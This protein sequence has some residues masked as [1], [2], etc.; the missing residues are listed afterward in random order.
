MSLGSWPHAGIACLWESC[1]PLRARLAGAEV[2]T[3]RF[4]AP[5][6]L[7]IPA[8]LSRRYR[9]GGASPPQTRGGHRGLAVQSG[10]PAAQGTQGSDNRQ[11]RR[12]LV[13]V[14]RL[15]RKARRALKG[16]PPLHAFVD[17]PGFDQRWPDTATGRRVRRWEMA[18]DQNHEGKPRGCLSRPELRPICSG[19]QG[20]PARGW[21]RRPLNYLRPVAYGRSGLRSG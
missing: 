11:I 3:A 17:H 5:L 14:V 12:T 21:G 19:A 8:G 10:S 20:I 6:P 16:V 15:R 4:A 2:W 18:G 9:C 1:Q 7:S 13:K